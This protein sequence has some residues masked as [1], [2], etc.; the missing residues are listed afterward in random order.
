MSESLSIKDYS[1]SKY[2]VL[3]T[4]LESL[5]LKIVPVADNGDCM[6]EAMSKFLI[7][8]G[9][10]VNTKDVRTIIVSHIVDNGRLLC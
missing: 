6:F 10:D 9:I 1:D 5:N 7:K 2:D 4:Q 3:R 8:Q